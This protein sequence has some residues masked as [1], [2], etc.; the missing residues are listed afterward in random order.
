MGV[1]RCIVHCVSFAC[2][3]FFAV[4]HAVNRHV[5]SPVVYALLH[6][7]V[8]TYRAANWVRKVS[9]DRLWKVSLWTYYYVALP[10]WNAG[11]R[12]LRSAG[13]GC[14]A[15]W[16]RTSSIA[17]HTWNALAVSWARSSAFCVSVW[18]A[19]IV[20]SYM[21]V[22]EG[23]T[24]AHA[25]IAPVAQKSLAR[26]GGASLAMQ[27]R[28]FLLYGSISRSTTAAYG[29]V[30]SVSDALWTRATAN[31]QHV[32]DRLLTTYSSVSARVQHRYAALYL[33][34]AALQ[35]RIWQLMERF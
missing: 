29:R 14:L 2:N 3:A 25:V 24:A 17:G 20:P 1:V 4:G 9:T 11:L 6:I 16:R 18:Y 23:A 26:V 27:A 5:V 30:A 28:F 13:T 31:W 34:M 7:V 19:F 15:L 33:R 21:R 22:W 32:Y 12:L 10:L 35:A 8:G